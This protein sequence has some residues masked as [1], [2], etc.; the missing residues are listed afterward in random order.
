M[1]GYIM[2]NQE[3]LAHE[4]QERFKSFYCGLCRSLRMRYGTTGA[5]TLSF[6]MTFLAILLNA[7]YE[8]GEQRG[9][10][11]CVPHPI[12]AHG[13]V[14]SPAI[15][16]AADM[17]IALAY[18]KCQDNWRDDKSL[19]SCAEAAVLKRVYRQI[20]DQYPRQCGAIERWLEKIH[21]IEDT[22]AEE[23][24]PPVNATG[25]MLGELFVYRD[26]DIWSDTLRSVGD[27]LG[28]FIYLM[29]AYD[30]VREDVRKKRYNP[31]KPLRKRED[32]EVLCREALMMMAADATAAFELLPIL[33]DADIL[34]NVLYSGI[35]MKYT[36]LQK[37]QASKEEG[38]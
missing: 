35:W 29:D 36:L 9:E 26:G 23:V 6:D 12:R 3:A 33:E 27:G 20:R 19:L 24:D 30:D 25:E 22:G 16:Y 21:V 15:D 14:S 37:K 4:S 8:P 11:R 1:F 32:Y 13:Y 31:L 5:A 34:R 38:S 10:E 17:N 7:L 18:H 2:T 28:R